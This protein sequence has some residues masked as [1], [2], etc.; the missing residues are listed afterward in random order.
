M[1][2]VFKT[3]YNLVTEQNGI[4]I[5][6][7]RNLIIWLIAALGLAVGTFAYFGSGIRLTA[8][9]ALERFCSWAAIIIL[10]STVLLAIIGLLQ[11]LN[12][13]IIF[14]CNSRKMKK[15][16]KIY[17]FSQIE[18]LGLE[19]M[20]FGDSQIFFLTAQINGKRIKLTSE[21]ALETLEKIAGFC[22]QKLMFQEAPFIETKDD[23][24]SAIS[25]L[26]R[27]F[28]G[29]LLT[30]L[31]AIWTGTG[32]FFLQNIIITGSNS[33]HGPLLWPLGF[34]IAVLGISD[35]IG[36]PVYRTL[37]EGSGWS[38]VLILILVS[39]TY[40]LICWR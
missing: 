4:I 33:E 34:W 26:G 38:K 15:G 28:F 12:T 36:I 29:I 24:T 2:T 37:K 5:V 27:C 30:V 8:D 11:G 16:S 31:G 17:D 7:R 19:K 39:G 20:P 13:K 25:G 22:K 23:Q 14:D 9:G 10:S 35:L 18:D 40:M 21:T 3:P 6:K 1:N 32:F